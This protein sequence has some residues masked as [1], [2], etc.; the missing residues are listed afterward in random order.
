VGP[1]TVFDWAWERWRR[2][3][4]RRRRKMKRQEERW[5]DIVMVMI[6]MGKLARSVVEG[7]NVE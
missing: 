7:G 2:E 5:V 1:L 3:D 4:R 6:K